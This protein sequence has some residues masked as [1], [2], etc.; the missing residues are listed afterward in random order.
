M[1]DLSFLF[2]T[3][4]GA[5]ATGLLAGWLIRRF[6]FEPPSDGE[7]LAELRRQRDTIQVAHAGCKG[8]IEQLS[9]EAAA[10][11]T[12]RAEVAEL[13]VRTGAEAELLATRAEL[14]DLRQKLAD[15]DTILNDVSQAET[16][17][18]AR[19]DTLEHELRLA[20]G[21]VEARDGEIEHL[22]E[23]LR[24]LREGWDAREAQWRRE[25]QALAPQPPPVIDDLT[26]IHGVGPQLEA[27]LNE[28]GIFTYADLAERTEPIVDVDSG[29]PLIRDAWRMQARKL[30]DAL[31]G[32]A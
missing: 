14:A 10:V 4:I 5:G 27:R 32:T 18:R 26:L 16:A 12:L 1:S 23:R 9:V 13:S 22:N 25:Q 2:L 6:F 8:R 17:E 31:Y 30:H 28:H 21:N 19:I 29:A 15:I 3:H 11:P 7:L 24:T 20:R